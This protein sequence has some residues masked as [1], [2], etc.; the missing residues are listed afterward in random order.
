MS[1][2]G[3]WRRIARGL[4]FRLTASYLVFFTLLLILI[5]VGF[6][7]MLASIQQ[8]Q[9]REGLD[10]D[11]AALRGYL[12]VSQDGVTWR[13]DRNNAQEEFIVERLRRVFLLADRE[14]KVI[15]MSPAYRVIG[16][17]PPAE[18]KAALRLR[19]PVWKTRLDTLGAAYLIR[20]GMFSEGG[21]HQYYVALGRPLS[22]NEALVQRF[23]LRYFATLP[24]ILFVGGLLGWLL[25]KRVMLPLQDVVRT[26]ESITGA[27]LSL[28]I[29]LR[30]AGDEL[31][32]LIDTFNRMIGRLENS[33]QQMR[34]FTTDVSHELRTPITAVRG[35]LEVALLTA[36]RE[37]ELRDAIQAALEETER[38]SNLVKAMLALSHA[39]SGQT[40]LR[41][42]RQDL[43]V[44]AGDVLEQFRI[45]AEEAGVRLMAG[46]PPGCEAEVDPTQF[47]RLVSNLL[48]NAIK[49]TPSGGEVRLTLK[50]GA[51]SVELTVADTG[52]GIPSQH[53]PHI[54]DRFYRVP[55]ADAG[56]ERGL[57]LGLSFVA[58]IVSA[59]GGKIDVSSQ[60][61]IG[62]RFVATLPRATAQSTAL[63]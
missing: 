4:G 33:F 37:E 23:T 1:P 20:S 50:P 2:L 31:D 15:D 27:S 56:S 29:P 25:T 3:P 11:W 30:G 43:S 52:C 41:K 54:F 44:L 36:R 55:G 58:W 22:L 5:G 40:V 17:D 7:D 51:A 63:V 12:Q 9:L 47:A 8:A 57:G 38:L 18:I 14:G 10:G 28:R 48:S 34:Q 49:Y 21:Q 39:E 62:S 53:L 46:L 60:P 16:P 6:R 19:G 26:S 35:Q 61:G 32:R 42:Q 24:V 59:H 13:W 45:L